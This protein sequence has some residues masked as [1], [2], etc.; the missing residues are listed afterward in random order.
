MFQI[1]S[2]ATTEYFYKTPRTPKA[3]LTN[4]EMV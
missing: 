3:C 4:L 2:Y 1:I